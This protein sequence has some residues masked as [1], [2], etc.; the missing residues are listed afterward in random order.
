MKDRTSAALAIT[1]FIAGG[2]L[3][4]VA[5]SLLGAPPAAGAAPAG[6]APAP[7]ATRAAPA[8]VPAPP[9]AAPD[10]QV[11]EL[12]A[13]L[14]ELRWDCARRLAQSGGVPPLPWPDE[15]IG[16][17]R[18]ERLQEALT[19]CGADDVEFD[20]SEMP[21][22]VFATQVDSM[23]ALTACDDWKELEHELYPNG[24]ATAR[25]TGP[26]GTLLSRHANLLADAE[27]PDHLLSRLGARSRMAAEAMLPRD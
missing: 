18:A 19:S 6:A 3:G 25:R 7:M 21:C 23:E 22:I 14:A 5:S 8:H 10:G 26:H 16:E 13:E 1:A 12:Q 11:E 4:Q 15:A 17:E 24:M 2:V 20:C 27:D 9:P